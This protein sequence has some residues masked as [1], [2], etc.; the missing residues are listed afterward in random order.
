MVKRPSI[1]LAHDK[2]S[3][4]AR[5]DV[6]TTMLRQQV[7][8]QLYER[9]TVHWHSCGQLLVNK[10]ELFAVH[11]RWARGD[12]VAADDKEDRGVDK[13]SGRRRSRRDRE[14]DLAKKMTAGDVLSDRFE[15]R[16]E[17]RATD[18][19]YAIL[20][21]LSPNIDIFL[22]SFFFFIILLN[23]VTVACCGLWMSV[24]L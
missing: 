9:K 11:V 19:E 6:L 24:V 14:Q 5:T 21:V 8:S 22:L 18:N 12:P 2:E 16:G 7:Y 3:S 13:E 1:S 15:S 4:P 20:L 17:L 10:S 23:L